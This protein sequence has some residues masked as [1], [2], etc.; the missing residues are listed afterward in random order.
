MLF[1]SAVYQVFLVNVNVEL[2][3]F[4]EK[5]RV[6]NILY[7]CFLVISRRTQFQ[8]F[9]VRSCLAWYL[10]LKLLLP[11]LKHTRVCVCVCWVRVCGWEGLSPSLVTETDKDAQLFDDNEAA[12]TDNRQ[13]L[14]N[15]LT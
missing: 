3:F 8:S 11:I 6:V 15:I 2:F 9:S 10:N 4:F 1:R 12:S 5:S 13:F 14:T 7:Y